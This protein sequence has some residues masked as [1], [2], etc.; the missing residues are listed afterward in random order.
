MPLL[1]VVLIAITVAIGLAI[2]LRIASPKCPK[3]GSRKISIEMKAS[4]GSSQ[5]HTVNKVIICSCGYD[6]RKENP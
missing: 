2:T 5:S 4:D 3:C 1:I 6:G